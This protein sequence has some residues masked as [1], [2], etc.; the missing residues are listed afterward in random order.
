[1]TIYTGIHTSSFA[2]GYHRVDLS[3]GQAGAHRGYQWYPGTQDECVTWWHGHGLH[4]VAE[5]SRDGPEAPPSVSWNICREFIS[6]D[7]Q[8]GKMRKRKERPSAHKGSPTIRGEKRSQLRRLNRPPSRRSTRVY[9]CFKN[10]RRIG[11]LERSCTGRFPFVYIHR[12]T[13]HV[14]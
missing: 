6:P 12:F 9:S 4:D 5:C 11:R 7:L 14:R 3:C 2:C 10:V 13:I 8:Q 1:M